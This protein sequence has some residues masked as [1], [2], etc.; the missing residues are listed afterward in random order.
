MN[1]SGLHTD[2]RKSFR[3]L[4]GIL[5]CLGFFLL[6]A[7]QAQAQ[8]AQDPNFGTRLEWDAA[9]SIWRFKWWARD[10]NTYFIQHSEDLQQWFWAPVVE[11]GDDS[12][13]EWDFASAAGKFFV[14]LRYTD[15]S[16]GDPEGGDFDGDGVSNLAEVQQGTNPFENL[17][18]DEDGVSNDAE[19]AQGS[20]PFDFFNGAAPVLT[21]SGGNNQGDLP[22]ET[23][24]Q[25]FVVRLSNVQGRGKTNSAIAFSIV[26]GGGQ[27]ALV[28][29]GLTDAS[30]LGRAT[31][32]LPETTGSTVTVKAEYGAAEVLLVAT[33]GNPL[34]APAAPGRPVITQE[35][36]AT[37]A[38]VEWADNSNNETAFYVERRGDGEAWT[39]I[40]ELPANTTSYTDTNLVPGELN[41]YRIIAHNEAP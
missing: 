39:R 13:K 12:I 32:T 2:N 29:G 19:I 30:G 18:S 22:G 15:A 36:G 10:G 23:L 41:L 28:N 26:S 4:A 35:D 16:T 17:D 1:P 24:A 33:V 27:L 5:L 6:P 20:N 7:V 37:T 3:F 14:R 21:V 38:L 11:T 25:P 40:A 34:G 31:L 8:T 9:N